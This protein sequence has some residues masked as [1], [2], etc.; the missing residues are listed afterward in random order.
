[1]AVLAASCTQR[2][3]IEDTS[4]D[5]TIRVLLSEISDKDSLRFDG[6]FELQSEEA[7]YVI[8]G[9]NT[10]LYI[11]P[12]PEG[13]QLF[14]QIRNLLFRKSFPITLRPVDAQNAFI[15]NGRSYYGKV[16][17]DMSD[18]GVLQLINQLSLET[19]LK[20]VVPAE[21]PAENMENF[22]AVKAQAIC[23]RTYSINK[24]QQ[25]SKNNYDVFADVRDQVYGGL[26]VYNKNAARAVDETK[27]IILKYE[28]KPATVFYHSTC[29]GKLEKSGN[30]FSAA[31]VPYSVVANDAVSDEF[32]CSISPRFRW[33]EERTFAQI[34]SSFQLNYKKSGLNTAWKDTVNLA[35]EAEVTKR[36]SSGRIDSMRISYMDTTVI[37]TGNEIRRFWAWPPGR[38]LWSNLFYLEQAGDSTILL[39]GGGF[40][41]GVGMCQWGAIGMSRK[42]LQYYHILNKYFPGT[43]LAKG[44]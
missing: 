31:N 40:G 38:M 28:G 21:I 20:C 18:K 9:R 8:G 23:A 14:N 26:E 15:Y 3:V 32:S 34:D 13:V 6:A 44:Y 29:G 4:P 11:Q 27:S 42:G 12:L 39:N 17:F 24:M 5:I 25:N 7:A 37:L 10:K 36:T 35:F 22:E 2:P 33:V 1:M 30:F 19:Y 41:H 16:V 43:V